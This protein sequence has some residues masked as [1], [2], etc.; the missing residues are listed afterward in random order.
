MKKK[1][2]YIY[3][4]AILAVLVSCD[5]NQEIEIEFPITA[6]IQSIDL[7]VTA[8]IEKLHGQ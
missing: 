3:L 8:K 2:N 4:F 7:I 6:K 1:F 5:L